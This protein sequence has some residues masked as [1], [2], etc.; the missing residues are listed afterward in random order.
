MR[1]CPTYL[2]RPCLYPNVTQTVTGDDIETVVI[3]G[4][5]YAP[6]DTAANCIALELA[7]FQH[8]Q[9]ICDLP[10]VA[11]DQEVSTGFQTPVNITLTG[12]SPSGSD[13]I[14]LL[15]TPPSHGSL[16]GDIPNLVYTPNFGYTGPDSFTF[17]VLAG[18]QE[19]APATV[20]ITVREAFIADPQ[21][22]VIGYQNPTP[23]FLT[24]S[25]PTEDPLIFV[26][27]NPPDHG[28]LTGTPPDL[29]YTP[30]N[31][32]DGPDSFEFT[33]GDGVDVSAPATVSLTVLPEE[34]FDADFITIQ[35]AFFDGSDLDTHT[36]ITEPEMGIPV[37]WCKSASS[38]GTGGEWYE[39]AGDNTGTGFES[40]L[41]YVNTIRTAY[42]T[43][44]IVGNCQAWW[45]YIRDSGNVTLRLTAYKGGDMQYVDGEYRWINV[46]GTEV[47]TREISN[48]IALNAPTCQSDPECVSGWTYDIAN[49]IFQWTACS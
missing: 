47:A 29:I 28:S 27:T 11:D 14:F 36:I 44:T 24:G 4:S 46:G 3:A 43:G 16:M 18:D 6:S 1:C 26:I 30:D 35:Y 48:N 8:A 2:D 5:I 41:I 7:E 21:E 17:T 32:Y 45:Y 19:S 23:I 37:G 40:V 25:G 38:I 33:V 13:L 39:W 31:G 12:S 22:Q 49:N 20:N 15:Q 34:A 10:P 42:P 9:A